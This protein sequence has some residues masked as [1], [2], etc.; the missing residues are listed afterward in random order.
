MT[1]HSDERL[2]ATNGFKQGKSTIKRKQ[3][4]RKENT[5]HKDN[6]DIKWLADSKGIRMWQIAEKYGLHES[7]FSRLLRH[8]LLPSDREKII[9]IIDKCYEESLKK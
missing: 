9:R 3:V 6:L 5:M 2:T 8:P 7:N 1:S 4:E